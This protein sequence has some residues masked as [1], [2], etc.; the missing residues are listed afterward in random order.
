MAT[1]QK[2]SDWLDDEYSKTKLRGWVRRGLTNEELAEKMG[3][4]VATLYNWKK[5][6]VEFLEVLKEDRDFCDDNV[7]NALYR[8]ALDGNVT[9]QIFYLKNRRRKDWKDKQDVEVSGEV[10]IVDAMIRK[11]NERKE[12]LE[13]DS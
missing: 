6:N 3:I 5:S 2:V 7:E 10:G 12:R 9:A 11:A 1:R 4:S 8:A 13:N